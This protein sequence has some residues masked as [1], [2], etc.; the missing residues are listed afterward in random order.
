MVLIRIFGLLTLALAMSVQADDISVNPAWDCLGFTVV[1]LAHK[2]E[3]IEAVRTYNLSPPDVHALDLVWD[4][5]SAQDADLRKVLLHPV[6]PLIQQAIEHISM[7]GEGFLMGANGGLVAATDKTTD[8]WQGDE[9]QFSDAVL[10]PD[11]QWHIEGDIADDSSHSMLIK[12][13]S[14]VYDPKTH[15]S[16][17]VLMLGFDQFVVDFEETCSKPTPVVNSS[18]P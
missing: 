8:F 16:I 17:G 6:T 18:N 12:I 10:L 14:P 5:F 7:Q 3:L 4:S 11:G 15:K 13:S 2:P 1:E 9:S